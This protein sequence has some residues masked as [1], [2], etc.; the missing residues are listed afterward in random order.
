VRLGKGSRDVAQVA[1]PC[2][3]LSG[4]RF[5]RLAHR[6]IPADPQQRDERQPRRAASRPRC[7]ERAQA[8]LVGKSD[9]RIVA[10]HDRDAWNDPKIEA[11]SS[12]SER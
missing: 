1:R 2:T 12:E 6:A 8:V 7:R 10:N 5:A 3:K 4:N 9:G 11:T